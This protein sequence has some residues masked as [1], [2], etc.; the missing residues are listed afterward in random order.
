MSYFFGSSSSDTKTNGIKASNGGNTKV[1][2][3]IIG[4]AFVDLFCF[5]NDGSSSNGLPELGA[6]VRI[7]QPGK[8]DIFEVVQ[9]YCLQ[10]VVY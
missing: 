3:S 7:S 9:H 1:S 5:L 4:D 2:V 8:N 10:I 6:D